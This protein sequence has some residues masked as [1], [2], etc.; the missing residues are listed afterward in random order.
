[1]ALLSVNTN[2]RPLGT[3]RP[4]ARDL[5]V[6]QLYIYGERNVSADLKRLCT[7]MELQ[8]TLEGAST[9]TLKVRDFWRSFLRSNLTQTRSRIVLDNIEYTLVKVSH[10]A[11]EITLILEET[12][13]NL[14][15]RY[16]SPKKANRDNTTR[17]QFI[18]GMVNE[19]RERKIPW[20]CPEEKIRQPV[21]DQPSGVNV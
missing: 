9:L 4:P 16:D 15:R 6:D 19:V 14:L 18:R 13:V 11:D 17:A 1:M 2:A 3:F 21:A 12:A 7:S 20:N 5:D 10:D 8:M